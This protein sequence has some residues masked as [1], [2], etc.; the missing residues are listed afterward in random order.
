MP[1]EGFMDLRGMFHFVFWRNWAKNGCCCFFFL[2]KLL[3]RW[4]NIPKNLPGQRIKC[5]K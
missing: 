5:I 2:R 3:I 1:L 4:G